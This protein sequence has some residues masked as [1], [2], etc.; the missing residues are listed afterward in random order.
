MDLD[1]VISVVIASDNNY[2]PHLGALITSIFDNIAKG[3]AVD[4][5]ILDGGI[6]AANQM[7][8]TRLIPNDSSLHF[9]PMRDEFTSYFTHM[10]FSR[11]TFYRLI[12]DSILTSRDKIIYIDCDTI[13]LGDLLELWEID[14]EDKPVA[15]VHDYIM[16]H[17]CKSNVLSADFAGSLPA[18]SYLREYV[19]ISA[20]NCD[21]YFQAGLLIMNLRRIRELKLSKRMTDSLLSRKYWFLDQDVLNKYF[22]GSQITLPAE[23]NFVNCTDDITSSLDQRRVRELEMARANPK[24]IHYAGYEAKPWVNQNAYMGEYYFYYLRRTHWY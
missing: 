23:W 10:H 1:S 21:K 11:A 24:L 6:S 22:C 3:T 15:A 18:L 20:K 16:E 9:I 4:L 8:L 14:M 17:F 13:V 19:G 7:M 2:V 12:L 5:L